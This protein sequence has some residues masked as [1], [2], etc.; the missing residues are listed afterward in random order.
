MSII[1]ASEFIVRLG[2][3][4]QQIGIMWIDGQRLGACVDGLGVLA[5]SRVRGSQMAECPGIPRLLLEY[6]AKR[7]LG[8]GPLLVLHGF[9][10][11]LDQ[12]LNGSLGH[13]DSG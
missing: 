5:L 4:H 6:L 11:L 2:L 10:C 7:T 12:L 9:L 3:L 8:L 13:G 1:E